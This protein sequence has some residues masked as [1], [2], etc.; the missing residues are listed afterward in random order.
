VSHLDADIYKKVKI[1]YIFKIS[2]PNLTGKFVILFLGKA[3]F[4]I[5]HSLSSD[6]R[7]FSNMLIHTFIREIRQLAARFNATQTDDR[8]LLYIYRG[9]NG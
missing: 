2:A 4:V 6:R 9:Q 1:K 8:S 5:R 7:T 3:G